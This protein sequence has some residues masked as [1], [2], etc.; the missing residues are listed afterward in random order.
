MPALF[1]YL[2][3]VGLLLGGGYGALSWLAAPEP[4]KVVAKAK[5][6]PHSEA[7]RSTASVVAGSAQTSSN[8][9]AAI[10]PSDSDK[11]ASAS[12]NQAPSTGSEVTT[13]RETQP[14][15]SS[16]AADLHLRAAHDVGPLQQNSQTQLVEHRPAPAAAVPPI[17]SDHPP[18][19]SSPSSAPGAKMVKR[20]QLR[21]ANRLPERHAEKRRLIL[22]TLRTIQYP[23]GR[24]VS[25]LLPYRGSRQALAS[26]RTFN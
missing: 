19:A 11:A 22:M 7:N 2:I 9:N 8:G 4:V 16:P 10:A 21:E 14:E 13:S 5:P 24:R 18:M 1:A 20:S 26:D 6:Q 12:N 23:D 3:A 15:A 17:S 25:R